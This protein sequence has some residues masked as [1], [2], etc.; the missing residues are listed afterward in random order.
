MTNFENCKLQI[1]TC[2]KKSRIL[3]FFKKILHFPKRHCRDFSYGIFHVQRNQLVTTFLWWNATTILTHS[4]RAAILHIQINTW[5]HSYTPK[6]T[7]S[8]LQCLEI[9]YYILKHFSHH[10]NVACEIF[11]FFFLYAYMQIWN[12][13]RYEWRRFVCSCKKK[14]RWL[15]EIVQHK[16][17]FWRCF[18]NFFLICCSVFTFI[19]KITSNK[20]F[21]L[22][23]IL[24]FRSYRHSR[25]SC[26]LPK[27]IQQIQWQSIQL[28]K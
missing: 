8:T 7:H 2:G 11:K 19:L 22:I 9:F 23:L 20:Y 14:Q 15:E 5:W 27:D 10:Y 24:R 4:S 26:S 3:C 17:K 1:E 18:A 28:F 16:L 21:Y 25:K 13:L 6:Y 12:L